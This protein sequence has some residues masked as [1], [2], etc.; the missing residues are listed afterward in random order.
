M[1]HFDC[2]PGAKSLPSFGHGDNA[3]RERELSVHRMHAHADTS[4]VEKEKGNTATVP[5]ILCLP[6]RLHRLKRARNFKTEE[7]LFSLSSISSPAVSANRLSARLSPRHTA[8]RAKD[9]VLTVTPPLSVPPSSRS[10]RSCRTSALVR[11]VTFHAVAHNPILRWGCVV[12]C[13]KRYPLSSNGGTHNPFSSAQPPSPAEERGM[14][15]THKS[16]NRFG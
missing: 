2:P 11:R 3:F 9:D 12:C 4:T 7:R 6:R 16:M 5:F 15:R 1:F 14:G 8:V 10:K 13:L